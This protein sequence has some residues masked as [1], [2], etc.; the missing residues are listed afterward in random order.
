MTQKEKVMTHGFT[1]F[2]TCRNGIGFVTTCNILRVLCGG[3]LE[4]SD[5]LVTGIG[6]N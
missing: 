4:H 5:P 1:F 6:F 3:I 2:V